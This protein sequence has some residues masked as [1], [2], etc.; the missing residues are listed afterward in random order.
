MNP[1]KTALRHSFKQARLALSPEER[2]AKSTAIVSHFWQ[3]VDWS[4]V[5]SLH[6]FE[7]IERLGEVDIS[8]FVEAVQTEYPNVKLFTSRQVDKTWQIISLTDGKT[9]SEAVPQ[10]DIITVPM[11]GFDPK[12]LHRVGY[13][14]GYYDRFLAT[15]PHAKKIGLCFDL[16][17]FPKLSQFPVEPHDIPLDAII[18]ESTTSLA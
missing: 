14:G 10:F 8:D 7:P 15:Q 4:A 9:V 6:C 1:T 3:A 17:Q 13:G 5:S 16:G 12:S 11:L 2:Q 18:T